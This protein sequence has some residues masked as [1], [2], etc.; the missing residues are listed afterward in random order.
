MMPVLHIKRL[1]AR[2]S[3]RGFGDASAVAKSRLDRLLRSLGPD[4]FEAAF[5]RLGLPRS[6]IIC[7]RAL[8]VPVRVD[9]SRADAVVSGAWIAAFASGLATAIKRSEGFVRYGSRSQ[10]LVD[11]LISVGRSDF[12]RAWAWRQ[13]GLWRDATGALG[14]G[15]AAAMMAL[16]ESVPAALVEVAKAGALPGLIA[17]VA[18][19][20]WRAVARA[21]LAKAGASSIRTILEASEEGSSLSTRARR[22]VSQTVRATARAVL[23]QSRLAQAAARIAGLDLRAR[24]AMAIFAILEV[25]PTALSRLADPRALVERLLSDSMASGP[26]RPGARDQVG[27]LRAES[28]GAQQ[29]RADRSNSID[30]N[31]GNRQAQEE[32]LP[33]ASIRHRGHTR[34]GGLLFLLH[35]VG[36]LGLP[37][38]LCAPGSAL[39]GRSLRWVLHQIAMCLLPLEPNDA[40]ALAFAGVAPDAD[41]PSHLAEPA[42]GPEQ[43]A[44]RV[45]SDAI[46][47]RL[48]QRVG[49]LETPRAA[50]LLQTCRRSAEVLA[51]PAW[52]EVCL[53]L[54]DVSTLL[55]RAGLDLDLGWL[56]WLGCVVR[57]RYA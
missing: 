44:V 25:D 30:Q 23:A 51:D 29:G 20:D 37:E 10:A 1:R 54:D 47:A 6:E 31:S 26:E 40:A 11:V 35:I 17:R 14:M 38:T 55:R 39:A 49:N 13:L 41:P 46:V 27:S 33:T 24:E 18:P 7:L 3:L 56:P 21:A 16:P 32:T 4:E 45:A 22:D 5:A 8:H 42:T 57:F 15:A 52:I 53:S 12:S 48:R 36:E 9:L 28:K 2:Y 34:A 19:D 43:H 50:L